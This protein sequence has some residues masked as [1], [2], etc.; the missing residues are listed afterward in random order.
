MYKEL[1]VHD[2][3]FKKGRTPYDW[4][5]DFKSVEKCP[6][7]ANDFRVV[8]MWKSQMLHV[9]KW[10]TN[11]RPIKYYISG[12]VSNVGTVSIQI[13]KALMASSLNT[14]NSTGNERILF[15]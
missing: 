10:I 15:A 5:A 12:H 2:K 14:L 13:N 7:Q 1:S 4:A 9:E 11:L 6:F 3:W 8:T